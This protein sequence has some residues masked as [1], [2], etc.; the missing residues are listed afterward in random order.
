MEGHSRQACLHLVC[1]TEQKTSSVSVPSGDQV[2]T[3]A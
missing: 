2:L 3:V 1:S